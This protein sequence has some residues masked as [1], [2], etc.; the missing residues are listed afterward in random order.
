MDNEAYSYIDNAPEFVKIFKLLLSQ[1]WPAPRLIESHNR[2]QVT[3][4][5]FTYSRLKE[6]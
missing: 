1:G 4:E 6:H 5:T 3:M 2:V